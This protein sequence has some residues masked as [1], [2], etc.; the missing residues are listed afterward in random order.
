MLQEQQQQQQQHHKN[1]QDPFFK[2]SQSRNNE[3]LG[4]L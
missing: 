3:T 4:P 1:W 2:V